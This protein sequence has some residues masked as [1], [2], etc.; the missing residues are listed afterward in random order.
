MKAVDKGKTEGDPD[1]GVKQ[2]VQRPGQQIEAFDREKVRVFRL[3][4]LPGERR[5]LLESYSGHSLSATQ[6][7]QGYRLSVGSQKGPES[8]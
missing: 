1:G 8:Q 2:F 4:V 6:F 7:F 3:R 5:F